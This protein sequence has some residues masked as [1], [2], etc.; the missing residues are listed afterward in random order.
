[1]E[2]GVHPDPVCLSVCPCLTLSNYYIFWNNP[3]TESNGQRNGTFV[4][5]DV[6]CMHVCTYTRKWHQTCKYA[7][8]V[9]L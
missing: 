8:D 6:E 7:C 4:Y 9:C 5:T 3:T 1:M 2:S